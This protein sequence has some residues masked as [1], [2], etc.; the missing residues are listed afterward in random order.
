MS[1]KGDYTLSRSNL[2]DYT[3][4]SEHYAGPYVTGVGLYNHT[5]VSPIGSFR[6][7]FRFLA[8]ADATNGRSHL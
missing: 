4:G 8:R 5:L 1:K 7:A 6:A 2:H 3:V